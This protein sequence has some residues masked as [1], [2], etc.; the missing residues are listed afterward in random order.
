MIG[1]AGRPQFD[2]CG[3]AVIMTEQSAVSRYESLLNEQEVIESR[4]ISSSH[5]HLED[6]INS[7][8]RSNATFD[9]FAC[10]CVSVC[11]CVC[12]CVCVPFAV[13]FCVCTSVT[14]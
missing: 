9:Y 6:M 1:R 2:T 10:V 14:N 8:V 12:V 5:S 4:V 7:E 13:V 3:T 11:V